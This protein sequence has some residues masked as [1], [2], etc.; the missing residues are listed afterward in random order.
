MQ[1]RIKLRAWKEKVSEDKDQNSVCCLLIDRGTVTCQMK[2]EGK[3]GG[4]EWHTNLPCQA[5]KQEEEVGKASW[6]PG[7]AG[8]ARLLVLQKVAVSV[9]SGT[10]LKHPSVHSGTD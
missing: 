7:R 5:C 10:A 4:G 2:T 6:L 1:T 8:R 9:Q 3:G